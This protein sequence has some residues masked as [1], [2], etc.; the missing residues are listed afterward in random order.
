MHVFVSVLCFSW[1]G[2]HKWYLLLKF[3]HICWVKEKQNQLWLQTW[4]CNQCTCRYLLSLHLFS[5]NIECLHSNSVSNVYC[6]SSH[7]DLHLPSFDDKRLSE[8]RKLIVMN[9]LIW[10][11]ELGP[12]G[13]WQPQRPGWL[14]S[15]PWPRTVSWPASH[16][17][18][19]SGKICELVSNCS[20]ILMLMS[21]SKL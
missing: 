7:L 5:I 3:I 1:I 18:L 19:Q 15:L 10:S 21:A 8:T 9:Q 17:G 11:H 4:D 2:S 6:L 13:S 16:G 20:S 12:H 14:V